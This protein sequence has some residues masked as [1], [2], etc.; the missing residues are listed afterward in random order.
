MKIVGDRDRDRDSVVSCGTI[1]R[2]WI[3]VVKT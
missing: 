2:K 1:E 3:F